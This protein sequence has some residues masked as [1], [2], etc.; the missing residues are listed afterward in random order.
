MGT[1]SIEDLQGLQSTIRLLQEGYS[2]TD[3][4]RAL[5]RLAS[6]IEDLSDAS[7]ALPSAEDLDIELDQLSDDIETMIDAITEQ[8]SSE[9]YYTVRLLREFTVT[10][11][12]KSPEEARENGALI[13]GRL[14]AG[15]GR[16]IMVEATT[17]GDE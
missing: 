10:T 11:S 14:E 3:V 13:T 16:I 12:A 9:R 1:I 4:Q 17:N 7:D 6:A 8:E 5:N 2:N 15:V